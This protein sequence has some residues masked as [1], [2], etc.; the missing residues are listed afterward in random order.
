MNMRIDSSLKVIL[1]YIDHYQMTF[2]LLQ[3]PMGKPVISQKLK[4]AQRKARRQWEKLQKSISGTDGQFP[5]DGEMLELIY[6]VVG[7]PS[8]DFGKGKGKSRDPAPKSPRQRSA[9]TARKKRASE[10]SSASDAKENRPELRESQTETIEA[11]L[12]VRRAS[13][14]RGERDNTEDTNDDVTGESKSPLKVTGSKEPGRHRRRSSVAGNSVD[15]LLPVPGTK[16]R[17]KRRKSMQDLPTNKSRVLI[18]GT[19]EEAEQRREKED[20]KGK[21]KETEQRHEKEDKMGKQKE[22]EQR[23]EKEYKNDTTPGK[24]QSSEAG[25]RSKSVEEVPEVQKADVSSVAEAEEKR[26]F[27][28]E[29]PAHESTDSGI[30]SAASRSD[31]RLKDKRVL[32]TSSDAQSLSA[33]AG[34]NEESTGES[35]GESR[36]RL[37]HRRNSK[38]PAIPEQVVAAS[39]GGAMVGPQIKLQTP[40]DDQQSHSEDVSGSLTSVASNIGDKQNRAREPS[41]GA[42]PH[43]PRIVTDSSGD[44]TG[45]SGASPSEPVTREPEVTS[46]ELAPEDI[47]GVTVSI[48]P[49]SLASPHRRSIDVTSILGLQQKGAGGTAGLAADASTGRGVPSMIDQEWRKKAVSSSSSAEQLLGVLSA[50]SRLVYLGSARGRPVDV[51]QVD[52]IS[53]TE[54]EAQRLAAGVVDEGDAEGET[55]PL[56]DE[57]TEE[58]ADDA[59]S[60]P[61]AWKSPSGSVIET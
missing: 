39:S 44:Q 14:V 4:D 33:E 15:T 60:Q 46:A 8:A 51:P 17:E 40:N 49:P 2:C 24:M 37:K 47:A 36:M 29:R 54:Q 9:S 52:V 53:A 22:A 21:Q 7:S 48:M 23:H 55:P 3:F 28:G 13:A 31:R 10:A 50:T 59:T 43:I 45:G 1:E 19:R 56:S 11:A 41:S 61:D 42:S 20:K 6:Q 58:P 34:S 27:R 26:S 18:E 30:E 12:K 35:A 25:Q 5:S 38:M 32:E 16:E 57:V